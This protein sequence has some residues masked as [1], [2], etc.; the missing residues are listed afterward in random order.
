MS[1]WVLAAAGVA[2][3]LLG[4]FLAAPAIAKRLIRQA[5]N[6]MPTSY[7]DR[8]EEEWLG[9]L[10][11]QHSRGSMLIM[12]LELVFFLPAV[13]RSLRPVSSSTESSQPM[14]DVQVIE[15]KSRPEERTRGDVLL[16]ISSLVVGAILIGSM[17][18]LARAD[19]R[20]I[21][22][23]AVGAVVV[24]ATL[25]G[26]Y[27]LTRA[28]ELD[29]N[30]SEEAEFIHAI[31]WQLRSA[32]Q[33]QEAKSEA[34]T[35]LE[36]ALLILTTARKQA[37]RNLAAKQAAEIFAD[38]ASVYSDV[39]RYTEQPGGPSSKASGRDYPR[40]QPHSP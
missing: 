26:A 6:R 32:R 5:A 10:E 28:R 40:L 3:G 12:A 9:E 34:I 4:V 22:V 33:R 7:R 11:A 29:G 38:L 18:A 37:D 35:K 14:S 2:L 19:A 25:T 23:A 17:T 39:E 13:K 16:F 20:S 21:A 31:E 8:Y 30:L 27:L 15:I 24:T 1:W 36:S